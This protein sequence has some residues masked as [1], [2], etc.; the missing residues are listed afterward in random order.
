M[1]T[2]AF[3]ELARIELRLAQGDSV[4]NGDVHV[5]R[6]HDDDPSIALHQQH[7]Q[8]EV[9]DRVERGDARFGARPCARSKCSQHRLRQ[10]RCHT[11]DLRVQDRMPEDTRL[12]KDSCQEELVCREGSAAANGLLCQLPHEL[13]ANGPIGKHEGRRRA[14]EALGSRGEQGRVAAAAA[15]AAAA[16]VAAAA[17]AHCACDSCTR[18]ITGRVETLEPVGEVGACFGAEEHLLVVRMQ[19]VQGH[20]ELRGSFCIRDALTLGHLLFFAFNIAGGVLPALEEASLLVCFPCLAQR[21]HL[22]QLRRLLHGGPA[23]LLLSGAVGVFQDMLRRW[24]WRHHFARGSWHGPQNYLRH[25]LGAERMH[26]ERDRKAVEDGYYAD[27]SP[28]RP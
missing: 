5:A 22:F 25:C 21:F 18:R 9:P 24:R 14:V 3:L 13:S 8:I 4:L 10:D 16:T 11:F 7:I 15:V 6:T 23:C 26:K 20:M 2:H 12:I 27:H 1:P 17:C 28:A 19:L